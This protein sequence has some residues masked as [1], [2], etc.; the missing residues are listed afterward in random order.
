MI[1]PIT[2]VLVDKYALYLAVAGVSLVRIVAE[3]SR[4]FTW[5]TNLHLMLAPLYALAAALSLILA[6]ENVASR[7]SAE[8]LSLEWSQF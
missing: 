7:V 4:A 8:I 3:V 2:A 1:M 6:V 5:N